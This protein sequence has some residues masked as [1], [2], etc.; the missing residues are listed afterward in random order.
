[1]TIGA[2]L[3]IAGRLIGSLGL[4]FGLFL[5]TMA[6]PLGVTRLLWLV[7]GK[8]VAPILAPLLPQSWVFGDPAAEDHWHVVSGGG[9]VAL[10]GLLFWS[11]VIFAIWQWHSL[12]SATK[13][14]AGV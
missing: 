13:A 14:G 10:C 2:V 3:K 9:F 7:P 6:V 5:F 12:R 4:A 1:M 11:A 8:V